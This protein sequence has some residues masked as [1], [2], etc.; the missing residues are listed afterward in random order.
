MSKLKPSNIFFGIFLILMII[1]S[2]RSLVQ[3]NL[4]KILTKVIPV[5]TINKE[6]QQNLAAFYLNLKGINTANLTL[7]EK[8]NKIIFI[9]Y[10]ATWCPPCIAEMPDLQKLYDN[11]KDSISFVF[12]SNE[13]P[14]KIN[15]FL[16]KN[17]F[18]LP[19]YQQLTAAPKSLKHSSIPT[20]FIIDKA[21]NIIVHK[22]GV[23]NWNSS[24]FY[25]K[26]D[27]LIKK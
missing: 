11:Y 13:N 23:A 15:L 16:E 26:L 14:D 9:N 12:I 17:K 3:V 10:W 1:P 4:Q 25:K 22:T 19:I 18:T 21:G 2:T 7:T 6:E 8:S 5:N 24:S 27:N 20:T